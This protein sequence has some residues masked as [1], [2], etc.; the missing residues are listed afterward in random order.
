[1]IATLAQLAAP[2]RP[3]AM[4]NRG[5]FFMDSIDALFNGRPGSEGVIGFAIA[6]LIA[7]LVLVL[8]RRHRDRHLRSKPMMTYHSI[9][10]AVGIPWR[11][12][13][14]LARI[15]RAEKLPS[16][17]TLMVSRGTLHHHAEHYAAALSPSR[18]ARIRRR[19][20]D[21]SRRLFGG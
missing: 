17:L 19:I 20:D 5:R 21:L 14:L 6:F 12:E 11:D 3:T 16:P 18:A 1:M 15:A 9:A 13:V 7:G 8:Y 10:E 2:T 4:N